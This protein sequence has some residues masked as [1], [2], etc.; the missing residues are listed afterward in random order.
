MERKTFFK[1][2]WT[3]VLAIITALLVFT[4]WWLLIGAGFLRPHG[5]YPSA[6]ELNEIGGFLGG[7]FAPIVLAWAA[8]TFFLQ[9]QQLV[10]S[11]ASMT[12]QAKLQITANANQ[13]SQLAALLQHREED[14]KQEDSRTA[15]RFS[16][17]S[18][19]NGWSENNKKMRYA[20]E[21]INIGALAVGYHMRIYAAN[22][23]G[24]N[25]IL[26]YDEEYAVPLRPDESRSFDIFVNESSD[27]IRNGFVCEIEALRA[28]K[29]VTYQTFSC[30]E[31]MNTF[32]DQNYEAVANNR[33]F[34]LAAFGG[35]VR[36][37]GS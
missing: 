11:M 34:K 4:D 18:I 22:L 33:R 20:T 17:R 23:V 19:T 16:L 32:E 3:I 31:H 25:R 2:T 14:R 37:G 7:T 6:A 9:R 5:R 26:I 27:I 15:P 30:N 1:D 24:E 29:R 35:E 10:A 21:I 13:A 28:D 8:R 12:R 36:K